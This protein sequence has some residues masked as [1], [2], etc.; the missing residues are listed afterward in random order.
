MSPAW[1]ETTTCRNGGDGAG[2]GNWADF[3]VTL[4]NGFCPHSNNPPI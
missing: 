3:P 2:K 4:C 1:P